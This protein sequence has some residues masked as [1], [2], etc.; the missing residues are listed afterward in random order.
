[1]DKRYLTAFLSPPKYVIGGIELDFFCPRHFITLQ[2]IDSP[3]VNPNNAHKM[4]FKDLFFAMRVC[5]TSSWVE[6]VKQPSFGDKIR[7]SIIQGIIQ[8][9]LL[10]YKLFSNYLSESMTIPKLWQKEQDGESSPR[11]PTNIPETL[12]IVTLLISKM[13]FSEKDAWNMPF[14]KAIWYSTSYAIQEGAE[15]GIITTTEEESE[16]SDLKR[17]AEFE[18]KIMESMNTKN[19]KR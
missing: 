4:T 16:Q 9:Q 19:N 18:S 5:S 1:M 13:G 14:S 17:L 8:K 12:S 11:R 3:F 6:A 10:S 7:Y 2:A 15:I